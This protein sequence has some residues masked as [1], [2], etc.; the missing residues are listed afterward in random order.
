MTDSLKDESYYFDLYDQL[1]VDI[2][3]DEEKRVQELYEKMRADAKKEKK[4]DKKFAND[5][6][7]GSNLI[8]YVMVEQMAG[9]RWK[10]RKETVKEWMERDKEKDA[11]LQSVEPPA[12]SNCSHCNSTKIRIVSRDLMNKRGSEH[13][14]VLFMFECSSCKKRMAFWEDGEEWKVRKTLC[15]K[16]DEA[17]DH[18]SS[19]EKDSVITTYICPACKHNYTETLDLS[20]NKEEKPDPNF[21]KD[22]KRFCFTDEKGKEYLEGKANLQRITEFMKEAE[23]R[24]KNKK[25]YE[26]VEKVQKLKIAELQKRITDAITPKNYSDVRFAE[27]S[28]SKFV[29]VGVSCIDQKSDREEFDSRQALKKIIEEALQGTNWRLMSNGISYRLGYL[30]FNLRAYEGEEEIKKLVEARSKIIL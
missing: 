11:K 12:I 8:W 16:C 28:M 26:A 14:E 7:R 21:E 30:S 3:R 24:E 20:D 23:E 1:T 27:P 2:C 18:K 19:K 15:P 29:S 4:L 13:E 10:K 17:M 6:V 25:V 22:K 5:I 9:E